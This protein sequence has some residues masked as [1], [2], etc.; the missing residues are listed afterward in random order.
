MK[1]ILRFGTH[2]PVL[3]KV[4]TKTNGSVLELGCGVSSTPLLFWLCKAQGRKFVTYDS[5]IRWIKNVG[6]PIKYVDN[7]D[8][9]KI[10]NT[11][12]SVA[13]LDHRPGKRRMV[14]ALRLKDKADFIILHDSEPKSEKHYQY[15]KIYPFFKHRF[16]YTK[17]VPNTTVI[18]NFYDLKDFK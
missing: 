17:F 10:E 15:E 1:R 3:V 7:W 13:F 12:W 16:H 18:S 4:M 8:D 5:N 9:A 2:I 11:H 6:Y 14:D